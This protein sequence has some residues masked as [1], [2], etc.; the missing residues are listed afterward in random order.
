MIGGGFSGGVG[1]EEIPVNVPA[2]AGASD[3]GV[4]SGDHAQSYEPIDLQTGDYLH[5]HTDL[6]IGGSAFPFGLG[7]RVSYNSGTRFED[8][9]L[10]LGWA[11]SFQITAL[12]ESDGFQGLGADSP[13]DAAAAMV[14]QVVVNDLLY[15]DKTV[16]RLVV[17]SVAHRWFMDRLIDN[18]VTISEPEATSKYVKLPDESYHPPPHLA[19]T[20]VRNPDQTWQA[21]TKHGIVLVFDADGKISSWKDPN[22]NTV[23]FTYHS[24]KLQSVQNGMNRVLSFTYSGDRISTVADGTGRKVTYSYDAAGNLISVKDPLNRTTTFQYDAEGRLAKVFY[25]AHP[26]APVV[27]NSYDSLGRVAMQSDA[28]GNTCFYY[29]S[30]YR[31]QEV[32]PLAKSRVLHFNR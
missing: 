21:T 29:F 28:K 11:H 6:T 10:G 18:V 15:G 19:G 9:P 30:P 12:P 14:E 26:K 2:A 25:P 5:E 4:N 32:D 16:E 8:G 17:A 31:S 1:N 24:G 13:I 7:F 22:N 27:T 23:G 20:L 3:D